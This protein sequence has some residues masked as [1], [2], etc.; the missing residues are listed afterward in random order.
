[1]PVVSHT[2]GIG[3]ISLSIATCKP[4][5][6]EDLSANRQETVGIVKYAGI[7]LIYVITDLPG[8]FLGK[9]VCAIAQVPHIRYG[10]R[11]EQRRNLAAVCSMDL[12]NSV[13]NGS[14][15]RVKKI[16]HGSV[17]S[18]M[19]KAIYFQWMRIVPGV[20]KNQLYRR[21]L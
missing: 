2:A 5:S 14:D 20:I 15:V 17:S 19:K 11:R 3:I 7:G 1:M 18:A 12:N 8:C 21:V 6:L 10:E 9:Q 16:H 4:F 13:G